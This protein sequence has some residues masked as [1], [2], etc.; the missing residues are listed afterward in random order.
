MMSNSSLSSDVGIPSTKRKEKLCALKRRWKYAVDMK[1]DNRILFYQK[2]MVSEN[3]LYM[4]LF[5]V[6][7]Q[8]MQ[9]K[10]NMLQ[11]QKEA[12]LEDPSMMS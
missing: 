11:N 9:W 5:K 3:R 12:L 8:N 6:H 1:W 4:T 10:Y 7:W 2:N